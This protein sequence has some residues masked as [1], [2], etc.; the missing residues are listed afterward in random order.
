MPANFTELQICNK[1]LLRLAA[2]QVDS[3]D[4]RVA[5]ITTESLEA[6]LCIANYALIRDIVL[7]DRVW[8]FALKQAVLDTP[9]E[10]KPLF[11]Y[12][13]SFL[14][15][16][17]CLNLWRVYQAG[18]TPSTRNYTDVDDWIVQARFLYVNESTVNIEYVRTLDDVSILTA[19]PQ[20]IDA[21]SLRLAIEMC[22]PLTESGSLYAALASE[23]ANTLINASAIDGS[24][25]KH[26]SFQ[27]TTITGSR[28]GY[29]TYRG[30]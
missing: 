19:T 23:Y 9:E 2:N 1:A 4:G 11:S 12:G 17:D 21:L 20:F 15:P 29:R 25:A 6:K 27:S 16:S 5:T 30:H 3:P 10:T 26:E 8:S 14:L 28:G 13:Q 18:N 7:E 24:Q 22:M